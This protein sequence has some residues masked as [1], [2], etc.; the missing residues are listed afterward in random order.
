MTA[1][2]FQEL[3]TVLREIRDALQP[4]F[5]TA[6][7]PPNYPMQ[8]PMRGCVCPP[9]TEIGCPSTGCPRRGPSWV[10]AS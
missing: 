8:P 2:D 10:V 1:K 4:K 6:P 9:G 3:L 5:V 7:Q